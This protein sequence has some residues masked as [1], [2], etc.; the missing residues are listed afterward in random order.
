MLKHLAHRAI[1]ELQAF[2]D[3]CAASLEDI[4]QLLK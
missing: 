2:L 4:A 3:A 1:I